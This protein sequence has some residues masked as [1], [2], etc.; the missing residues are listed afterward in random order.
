M[1]SWLPNWRGGSDG[2]GK[3]G[4]QARTPWN[5]T[6]DLTQHPWLHKFPTTRRSSDE[7]QRRGERHGNL[8]V[9]SNAKPSTGAIKTATEG[10]NG[11]GGLTESCG[12]ANVT[13]TWNR[14]S[15]MS[16]C[17]RLRRTRRASDGAPMGKAERREWPEATVA[18]L[19]TA[20]TGL[21]RG[22]TTE[23]RLRAREAAA[24]AIASPLPPSEGGF[25]GERGVERLASVF[26][27]GGSP[28]GPLINP[29]P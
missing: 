23:D 24:M 11:K 1:Q 10:R 19:R 5:K 4:I 20:G 15:A 12:A 6:R 9:S 13:R 21:G 22:P 29:K 14:R 2:T 8:H 27:A 7:R 17:R 3:V 25:E 18:P 16:C 28:C 26:R